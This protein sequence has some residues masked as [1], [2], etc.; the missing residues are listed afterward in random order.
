ML[1]L[2]TAT[3]ITYME[4]SLKTSYVYICAKCG[5]Q[6]NPIIC[7]VIG[8][9]ENAWLQKV[10]LETVVRP[11]F[12]RLPYMEMTLWKSLHVFRDLAGGRYNFQIILDQLTSEW[13]QL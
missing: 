7:G 9:E 13:S 8:V 12:L 4:N 6:Q 2:R 1:E 5:G 10:K 11:F 3:V